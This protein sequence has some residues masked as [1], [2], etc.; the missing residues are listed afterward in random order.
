MERKRLRGNFTQN[1]N[2]LMEALMRVRLSGT[3]IAIVI[4][5]IR[6]T[7]GFHKEFKPISNGGFSK[8]T[9]LDK[10][11]CIRLV[12]GLKRNGV[13]T[14][15]GGETKNSPHLY[16]VNDPREWRTEFRGSDLEVTNEPELTIN[17]DPQIT[18]SGDSIVTQEINPK[19]SKEKDVE[20]LKE[21]IRE[22]HPF[23]SRRPKGG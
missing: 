11:Y 3:E 22:E 14:K 15:I 8:Q 9:G 12:R 6:D 21:K 10:S 4:T 1:P 5:V 2:E 16:K 18:L 20:K 23:L 19:E 7:F 17:S 13:I